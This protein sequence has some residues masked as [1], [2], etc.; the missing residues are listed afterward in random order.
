[1]VALGRGAGVAQRAMAHAADGVGE[2]ARELGRAFAIVLTWAKG[3]ADAAM[4][5]ARASEQVSQS[6][7]FDLPRLKNQFAVQNTP[8]VCAASNA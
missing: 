2:R 1:M 4:G 6:Q 7:A 5:G 3:D 8:E